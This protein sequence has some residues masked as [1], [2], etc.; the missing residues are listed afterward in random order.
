MESAIVVTLLCV[1]CE[2]EMRVFSRFK[3]IFIFVDKIEIIFCNP[4]GLRRVLIWIQQLV[5]SRQPI[6]FWPWYMKNE[7]W[8]LE[9]ILQSNFNNKARV[10]CSYCVVLDHVKYIFN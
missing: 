9:Y 2:E 1:V 8:I 6:F 3:S 4:I 7:F 10:G 5:G